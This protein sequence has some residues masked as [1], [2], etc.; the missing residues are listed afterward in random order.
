MTLTRFTEDYLD[1]MAE[2]RIVAYLDELSSGQADPI[3]SD[4][5]LSSAVEHVIHI[6]LENTNWSHSK[7]FN[8]AWTIAVPI[9]KRLSSQS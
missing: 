3:L 9:H 2:R 8:R 1:E 5:D 7:C 6:Y 4:D